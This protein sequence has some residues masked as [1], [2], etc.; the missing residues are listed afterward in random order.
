MERD[1]FKEPFTDAEIR[2]LAGD[3]PLSEIF[4]WK[5]PSFKAL[6]LNPADLT[7]DDLVRLM[8]GE[9]RLIRRPLVR[10]G[11]HLLVGGNLKDLEQAFAGG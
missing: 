11:G 2:G 5:S 3:R 8:M 9:P 6:G 10:I 4:S 1:F 7:E